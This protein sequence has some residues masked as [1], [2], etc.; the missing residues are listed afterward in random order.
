M[1]Y[2][3]EKATAPKF[4][5]L[6]PSE[7]AV[8]D[9]LM[10][11]VKRIRDQFVMRDVIR[12]LERNDID[13]AVELIRF[14]VGEEFLMSSLPA[15]LRA[16]YE[17]AGHEAARVIATQTGTTIT[18]NIITPQAVQWVMDNAGKLIKEWGASSREAIRDYIVRA[19]QNPDITTIPG[20]SRQIRE[21]LINDLPAI[22]GLTKQQ[23]GWV[24]NM[25]AR[26]EAEGR[27]PDQ[28]DRMVERYTKRL[29]KYRSE[30]IARTELKKAQIAAQQ[31]QWRQ[32]IEAGLI[33]PDETEME[34]MTREDPRTCAECIELDGARAKLPDGEFRADSG[35]T[36]PGPPQ[37][38]SC[39][40]AVALADVGAPHVPSTAKPNDDTP[41]I[42]PISTLRG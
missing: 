21:S 35:L 8:R 27:K 37:H 6:G 39:R 33:D 14:E 22:T 4:P 11:A 15:H 12:A 29:L 23:A 24:A 30:M 2:R 36:S 13:G 42:R 18:F 20:L 34:W 3:I 19:F 17:L 31:E 26:L 25:R 38:P 1:S 9:A 41:G 16:A 5:P 10:F 32:A 7:K 40:C 28:V